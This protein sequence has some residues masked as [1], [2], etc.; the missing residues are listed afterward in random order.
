MSIE[1]FLFI[2][3]WRDGKDL[4]ERIAN[5]N[6]GWVIMPMVVNEAA[7]NLLDSQLI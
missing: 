1:L 3:W 5:S 2:G 4:E 6:F 7:L